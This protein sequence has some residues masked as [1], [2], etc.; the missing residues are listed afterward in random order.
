[1]GRRCRCTRRR[2]RTPSQH[3]VWLA[4]TT[5][6]QLSDPHGDALEAQAQAGSSRDVG[7]LLADAVSGRQV[8]WRRP[9]PDSRLARARAQRGRPGYGRIRRPGGPEAPALTHDRLTAWTPSP[10][11]RASASTRRSPTVRPTSSGGSP[12]V[13]FRPPPPPG[14]RAAAEHTLA[15]GASATVGPTRRRLAAVNAGCCGPGGQ[16]RAAARSRGRSVPPQRPSSLAQLRGLAPG[17]AGRLPDPRPQVVRR[18]RTVPASPFALQTA[19]HPQPR[20]AE[21]RRAA[22]R[23]P[24]LAL[25][26][27]C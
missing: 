4:R 14:R 18:P 24:T 6:P 9:S 27:E 10:G 16:A 17:Q 3:T 15:D 13:R 1:M 19:Q 2:G 21:A 26:L 25:G 23:A 5:G 12:Q 22:R 11:G 7:V 20:R 8:Q